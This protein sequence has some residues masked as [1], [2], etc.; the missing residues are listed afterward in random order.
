MLKLAFSSGFAA[1]LV[2]LTK[3]LQG[4]ENA[5]MSETALIDK[6]T[7]GTGVVKGAARI[8]AEI[9]NIKLSSDLPDQSAASI[10]SLLLKHKVMLFRDQSRLDKS[11]QERFAVRF[12]KLAPHPMFGVTKGT[13]SILGLDS[14]RGG[15]RVQVWHA[16]GAVDVRPKILMV[17]AVVTPRFGGDTAWSSPVAVSRPA[18]TAPKGLQTRSGSFTATSSN[19]PDWPVF[20]TSIRS[21]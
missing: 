19:P 14:A 9:R 6:V 2:C 7:P 16:D 3:T 11:E 10:K 4:L 18:A 21:I 15:C 17:R 13:A 5:I 20:A 12:T 1:K 8:S